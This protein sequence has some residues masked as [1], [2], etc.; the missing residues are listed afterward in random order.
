MITGY[1]QI[2]PFASLL[3]HAFHV[4][5]NK[6]PSRLPREHRSL[7]GHRVYRQGDT[8]PISHD[9]APDGTNRGKKLLPAPHLALQGSAQTEGSALIPA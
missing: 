7:H 2:P 8:Q 3:L 9:T 6:R 5:R 4:P 1:E